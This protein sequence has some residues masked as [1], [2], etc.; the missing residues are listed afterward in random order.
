V[1]DELLP[2]TESSVSRRAV[3]AAGAGGVGV[4]ALAACSAGGGGASPPTHVS[5]G[6]QL[7]ALSTVAV[8]EAKSVSLPD[9]SPGIVARPTAGT[10]VCF[11]AIC[12]HQGC[13]VAPNGNRLDCPCH[14]SRYNALTGAVI[15]GPATQPLAKIPVT[16]TNGQVVTAA[17]T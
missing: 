1:S 16:V 17:S 3:L 14:G 15:N 4:V 6:K 11:S 5:A 8:G 2:A 9:G 7:T 12:T 10:A 13:T